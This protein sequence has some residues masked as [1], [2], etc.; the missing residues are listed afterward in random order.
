MLSLVG[1]TPG[2]E[3]V[4]A[5]LPEV[6]T[7]PV[8][9]SDY[10]PQVQIEDWTQVFVSSFQDA[11][12]EVIRMAPTVLAA[13]VVL[14]V[15]YVAARLLARVV[16]ALSDAIGLQTAAERSGLVDSMKQAGI[17]R[18]V[19]AILGQ[20][21]FWLTICLFLSA[22][23]NILQWEALSSAM[24]DVVGYIPN[25]LVATVVV[26]V[27]LLV[28]TFLRGVIA[29]S[30]DRVGLSYA[31]NLANGCYYV[32]A[33][34]TFIAAFEQLGLQFDLLKDMILIAFGAVAVGF[35]LAFGLGGREVMG[36][37]L[38]GYY[39]RQRLH[40][41]DRVRVAGL[42]GT[43]REVGPVATIVETVEDGLLNRH[44]VPNTKMLNEAVR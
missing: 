11:F 6:A 22:S 37:I 29:T 12:R 14:V 34:M 8:V 24:Q 1:Q 33:L 20:I 9:E 38:A 17:H 27:G 23:F 15:G 35:G 36:G 40:A 25:L 31:E 41:G 21:V 2:T 13:V 28:A 32:L 7:T 39:T 18:S 10:M 16:G 3:T 4:P 5:T 42:E 43:V 44:S 19:S 30:A 26:V